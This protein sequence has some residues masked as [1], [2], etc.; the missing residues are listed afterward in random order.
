MIGQ[1]TQRLSYRTPMRKVESFPTRATKP[2]PDSPDSDSSCDTYVASFTDLHDYLHWAARYRLWR[3]ERELCFT[4][5]NG[6]RCVLCQSPAQTVVGLLNISLTDYSPNTFCSS[7]AQF[8][9]S[10]L[11]LSERLVHSEVLN[12]SSFIRYRSAG[13]G[14]VTLLGKSDWLIRTTRSCCRSV[15]ATPSRR[16]SLTRT[17]QLDEETDS[18]RYRHRRLGRQL[19][20]S[21]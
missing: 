13:R 5:L 17:L 9:R 12:F 3:T 20:C 21:T 2:V 18:S 16:C 11:S 19:G 15:H 8:L 6:S 1:S 4:N 14:T 10:V 7:S